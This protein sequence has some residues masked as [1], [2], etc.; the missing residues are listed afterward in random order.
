MIG[1][2]WSMASFHDQK[3][4]ALQTN[5]LKVWLWEDL[6]NQDKNNG[7]YK[8]LAYDYRQLRLDLYVSVI[9]FALFPRDQAFYVILVLS[10]S[11]YFDNMLNLMFSYPT[12]FF[13]FNENLSDHIDEKNIK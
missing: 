2:I 1:L 3:V 9:F 7:F 6:M 10:T 4:L 12:N 11:I 8:W 13:T 5:N